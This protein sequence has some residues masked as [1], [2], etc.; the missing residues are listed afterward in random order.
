MKRNTVSSLMMLPAVLA[1]SS[2][3][4]TYTSTIVSS[5]S[6]DDASCTA[7]AVAP[8]SFAWTNGTTAIRAPQPASAAAGAA[9]IDPVSV[10]SASDEEGTTI[11]EY[12]TVTT[13]D[14]YEVVQTVCDSLSNCY[15]TTDLQQYTTYTATVDGILTV[16]TTALPFTGDLATADPASTTTESGIITTESLDQTRTVTVTSCDDVCY[17]TAVVETLA[18][19]TATVDGVETVYT[20]YCP[21]SDE[22]A[23][24]TDAPATETNIHSTVITVTSCSEDKC[25]KVE[26]TTGLTTVTKD[27]TIYTTYCPLT[28]ETPEPETPKT[29][30]NV[31]STIITVTSCED[32]KCSTQTKATGLTTITKDKTVYTTYCPLTSET[33][34]PKKESKTL[35]PP[36]PTST[37]AKTIDVITNNIKTETPAIPTTVVQSSSSDVPSVPA[38]STYEGKAVMI[39]TGLCAMVASFVIALI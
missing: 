16:I 33:P 1:A 29:K 17:T 28:T 38:I 25:S 36:V 18:T 11:Y 3:L 19:T 15:L 37:K 7:S 34:E 9:S 30:T 21:L 14:V 6:C 35:E 26:K 20:T 12:E 10:A 23:S 24:T 22:P 5:L 4:S 31:E 8:S 2:E 13:D 27:N 39:R 32:N